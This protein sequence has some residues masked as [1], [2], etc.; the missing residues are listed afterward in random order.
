MALPIPI[1]HNLTKNERDLSQTLSEICRRAVDGTAISTTVPVYV[2]GAGGG[3]RV[4]TPNGL[5]NYVIGVAN[6]GAATSTLSS[7]G[8]A[9]SGFAATSPNGLHT[10]LIGVANTGKITSTLQTSGASGAAGGGFYSKTPNGLHLY[11]IS[12]SNNGAVTSTK[13]S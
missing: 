4:T 1:P 10:Y 6:D 13:T 5:H 11:L 9:G 7:S 2:S 3:I 8:S 12:V